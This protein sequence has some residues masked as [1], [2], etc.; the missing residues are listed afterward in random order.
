MA[1]TVKE[2]IELLKGFDDNL[3]V[4]FGYNYGD[5][6]R[7]QV[8][9]GVDNAEEVYV[10]HSEYHQMPKVIDEDD[11]GYGNEKKGQTRVLLLR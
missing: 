8:A 4:H 9:P 11:K 7:T 6:W 2:L 1:Y 10:E 3:P 5:H